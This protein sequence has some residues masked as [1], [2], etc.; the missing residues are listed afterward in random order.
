MLCPVKPS[1]LIKLIGTYAVFCGWN[2]AVASATAEDCVAIASSSLDGVRVDIAEVI[3]ERQDLPP[4]CRIAGE[5]EPSIGFETRLPMKD[6]NGK[7]LMSG[8]GAYCGD[9]NNDGVVDWQD[10]AWVL[11]HWDEFNNPPP[12]GDPEGAQA[13]SLDSISNQFAQKGIKIGP[14][15]GGG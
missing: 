12:T 7:F 2:I 3:S 8:C 4:F 13:P 10:L 15:S 11:E 14:Q 5:I 1:Y 9:F 6:W